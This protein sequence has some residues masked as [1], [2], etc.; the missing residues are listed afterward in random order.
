MLTEIVVHVDGSSRSQE[1]CRAALALSS[2]HEAH[3]V[4]V[5]VSSPVVV[6]PEIPEPFRSDYVAHL[7]AQRKAAADAAEKLFRDT[8]K[9]AGKEGEWRVH[10]GDP[11]TVLAINGRYADLVVV[12]QTPPDQR[13]V[14]DWGEIPERLVLDVGRPVMVIPHFGQFPSIA[15]RIVV[16]W[17]AS[18]AAT[19]AVNDAMPLLTKAKQVVVLSINPEISER[20]HGKLPG[21]DIALSLARHGVK[22]TVETSWSREV[23]TGDVLLNRAFDAGADLIVMGAYGHTRLREV[24][25]GGVT[26]H[27]LDHMTA[28]VLMSH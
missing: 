18:R 20:R 26:N 2:A 15:E 28:P 13:S 12:G 5:F 8:L 19:R 1:I 6:I 7:R 27:L 9:T 10:E 3:L 17:D 14:P 24:L 4:G 22:A 21:A 25:L 16:A 11:S 23:E